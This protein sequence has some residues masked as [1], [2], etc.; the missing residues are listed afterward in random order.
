MTLQV[1]LCCDASGK[2]RLEVK[3]SGCGKNMQDWFPELEMLDMVCAGRSVYEVDWTLAMH[4][5]GVK[6]HPVQVDRSR[7]PV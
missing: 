4:A 6:A 3:E 1:M 2:G 7:L 5:F